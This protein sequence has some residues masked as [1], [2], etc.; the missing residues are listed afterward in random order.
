[1]SD[2]KL[3]WKSIFASG[4]FDSN[5]RKRARR[6]AFRDR[7]AQP[8]RRIVLAPC[9][10]T[11]TTD[12][13]HGHSSISLN[14]ESPTIVSGRIARRLPTVAPFLASV[15]ER[16]VVLPPARKG[17]RWPSRK[18]SLTFA[19]PDIRTMCMALKAFASAQPGWRRPRLVGATR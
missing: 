11:G 7:D 13:N 4:P 10:G 6:E 2:P 3:H 17:G 16:P 15:T 12:P 19:L 1:M 18:M 8:G 9:C 5:I 14:N